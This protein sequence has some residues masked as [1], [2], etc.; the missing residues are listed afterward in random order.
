VAK[1]EL[2]WTEPLE[3]RALGG[4]D[5]RAVAR[6][7]QTTRSSGTR[8][9]RAEKIRLKD[10]ED[11]R[12]FAPFEGIEHSCP[13]AAGLLRLLALGGVELLSVRRTGRGAESQPE[14]ECDEDTETPWRQCRWYRPVVQIVVV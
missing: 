7:A 4:R 8:R 1:R 13:H 12:A 3:N 2:S 5:R 14:N 9:A 10:D 11:A 6:L